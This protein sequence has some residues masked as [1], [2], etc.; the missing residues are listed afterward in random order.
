[1]NNA[2]AAT[3]TAREVLGPAPVEPLTVEEPPAKLIIDP[4]LPDSLRIG[5]V[6]IQYYAQNLHIRPVYGEKALAVS[7]RI[8][9]IHVFVDGAQWHWLDASGEPLTFNGFSPG[10]HKVRIVLVNANHEP[11]D[12]GTVEFVI[13]PS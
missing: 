11:L 6:V 2:T 1:M 7:P 13:P 12:E 9:H 10:P 8:G 3:L 4:P 5:R